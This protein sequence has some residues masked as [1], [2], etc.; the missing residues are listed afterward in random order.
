MGNNLLKSWGSGSQIDAE[1]LVE[2]DLSMKEVRNKVEN[3]N[4][5]AKIDLAYRIALQTTNRQSTD[6]SSNSKLDTII[7]RTV[8]LI[9]L[10]ERAKQ[11]RGYTKVEG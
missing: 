4:K 9:R 8:K 2:S 11:D 10:Y 1:K 6:E 3:L 5:G 7:T